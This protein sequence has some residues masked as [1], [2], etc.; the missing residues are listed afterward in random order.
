MQFIIIS[1]G[2]NINY[3][4]SVLGMHNILIL[5]S[6]GKQSQFVSTTK[7]QQQKLWRCRDKGNCCQV[8]ETA[9]Q[10][11]LTLYKHKEMRVQ[12]PSIQALIILIS[13]LYAKANI[14][15]VHTFLW[16]STESCGDVLKAHMNTTPHKDT[17]IHTNSHIG[18]SRLLALSFMN[19]GAIEALRQESSHKLMAA[20]PQ[21]KRTELNRDTN[22]PIPFRK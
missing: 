16:T 2:D 21:Y 1:S 13:A 9:T 14:I 4:N 12:L 10:T 3:E 8:L 18:Q 22:S 6:W 5:L 15:L 7:Q 11:K 20:R 19:N 17:E